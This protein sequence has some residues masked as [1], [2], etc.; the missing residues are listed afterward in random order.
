M[1]NVLQRLAD[2]L[3]APANDDSPADILAHPLIERMNEREVADLPL[4]PIT[5]RKAGRN[6]CP[7]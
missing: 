7:A 6:A 1:L 5:K 3:V 4:R 2:W